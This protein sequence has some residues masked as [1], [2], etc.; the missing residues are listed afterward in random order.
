VPGLFKGN[1]GFVSLDFLNVG[2]LLNKRW[3]HIMEVPF[4]SGGGNPRNFVDYLGMD[5][6]GKYVYGVRN[7]VDDLAIRQVKGES[8]WAI[9]AT[10]KYEF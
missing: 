10:V 1:K 7:K 8:Q 5:A 4:S 3:G 2:N 9:Q 6:S